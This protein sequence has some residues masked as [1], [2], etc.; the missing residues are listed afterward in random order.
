MM[1]K[2]RASDTLISKLKEFEGLRL[3]AYKPTKAERWW[4]I[5]YGHS[6]GDV[7]AGMRINEEKA[8][9]LLRRDLFF[10]EKFINGIPKVR[11]QGQFDALVS[12][13][14]N[15][16]V[17]NLKSSTLLKKIMHD[18]P[19]VE[20]QREFMKWVNSGGKQLAGLVKRRKWEAERWGE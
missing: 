3:V 15:V 19:T 4:T 13:A 11:T 1:M 16:G 7:R 5:G 10:V 12:F 9:E 6:A 2:I 20:I 14:Y 18:A 8:E 17:G